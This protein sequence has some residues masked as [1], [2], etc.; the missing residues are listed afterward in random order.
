MDFCRCVR[1]PSRRFLQRMRRAGMSPRNPRPRGPRIGRDAAR[2][3]RVTSPVWP[4]TVSRT[5]R[6]LPTLPRGP[7][8]RPPVRR[9]RRRG[10]PRRSGLTCR[11]TSRL[12]PGP[13]GNP[14]ADTGPLSWGSMVLTSGRTA[15]SAAAAVLAVT[16]LAL[17]GCGGDD[18]FELQDW[19]RARPERERR[20]RPDPLRPRWPS[21]RVTRG[22]P[23]TT[24]LPTS[25]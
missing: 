14:V 1:L 6:R 15:R 5:T 2:R 10:A 9:T 12:R 3:A 13:G 22:S 17:S 25:G 23:V 4:G 20:P 7:S 8:H 18:S 24:C 16:A 11:I 19:A 21:P